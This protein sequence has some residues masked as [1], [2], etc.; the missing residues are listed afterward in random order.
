MATF[1]GI[2]SHNTT[3]T[4]TITVGFPA[5][6]VEIV[7]GQKSSVTQNFSHSSR[8]TT[9]GTVQWCDSEYFDGT[10]PDPGG[11]KTHQDRIVSHWE[12]VGGVWTEKVKARI[13]Q[14]TAPWNATQIKYIVDTADVN[15][16]FKIT[17]RG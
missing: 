12:R 6:E 15:Y 14:S 16:P 7:I 17:A 3:G 11:T 13:D 5:E 1:K 2:V 8:G 4:K 10:A 9:D